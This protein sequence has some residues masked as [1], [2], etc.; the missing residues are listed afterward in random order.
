METLNNKTTLQFWII[1][2][3]AFIWNIIGVIAYLNQA[4]MGPET[5]ATLPIEDQNYYKNT[6]TWVT[7][8][9]GI[10][11]FCGAL[12]SLSL[13]LRKKLA[14][15]FFLASIIGVLAQSTYTFFIQNHIK[16]TPQTALMPILVLLFAFFLVVF[17]KKN[18]NKGILK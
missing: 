18:E 12:G 11:V 2:S 6:P 15:S 13:L 14:I 17:S 10:A 7:A 1:S 3:T 16:I 5:L 8:S 4:Y 9:F